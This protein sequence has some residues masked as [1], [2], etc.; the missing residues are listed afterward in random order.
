M[1]STLVW[2]LTASDFSFICIYLALT[3]ENR[4]R[5]LCFFLILVVQVYII[6]ELKG[7]EIWINGS[8]FVTNL[9]K[10]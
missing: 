7:F 5:F 1:S 2:V 8:L 10:K 6:L 9:L 4:G 3:H